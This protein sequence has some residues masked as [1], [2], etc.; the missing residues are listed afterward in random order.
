MIFTNFFGEQAAE[1]RLWGQKLKKCIT[2][3]LGF[4]YKFNHGKF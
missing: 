3:M 4:I 2:Q 1:A